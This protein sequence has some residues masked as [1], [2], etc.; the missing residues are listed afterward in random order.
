MRSSFSHW[1]L[2][3]LAILPSQAQTFSYIVVQEQDRDS[4]VRVSADGKTVTTI[5]HGAAG[6][7]VAV[8]KTGSY[9]IASKDALLRVT[10]SGEVTTIAK[11]PPESTWVSVVVDHKGSLIVA[12]G[13]KPILWRVSPDGQLV[14]RLAEFAGVDTYP[15]NKIGLVIDR[16]GDIWALGYYNRRTFSKRIESYPNLFRVTPAG[17]VSRIPLDGAAEYSSGRMV[18]DGSDGL[19]YV[20]DPDTRKLLRLSR[21]GRVTPF[22]DLKADSGN[23]VGCC[24]AGVARSPADGDL[25]ITIVNRLL[26]V[27]RNG[28]SSATFC[29]DPKIRRP[30]GI[31]V[32]ESAQ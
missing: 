21:N 4:L 26:R 8:E 16:T 30:E 28:G 9:V 17:A 32:E 29:S 11:A 7:D 14:E 18:T 5:A 25:I 27:S 13:K 20:D 12:D 2:W 1:L 31:V 10:R 19:V 6:V 3:F 15:V 22:A 23:D 24:T